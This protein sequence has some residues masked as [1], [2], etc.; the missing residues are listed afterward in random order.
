MKMDVCEKCH[1]KHET[2]N[3]CEICHK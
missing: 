1:A 2:S 3:N